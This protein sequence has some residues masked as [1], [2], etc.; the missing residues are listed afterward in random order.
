[1]YITH[2]SIEQKECTLCL[3]KVP[4]YDI[5]QVILTNGLTKEVCEYCVDELYNPQ[6]I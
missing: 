2:D 5:K 4:Y 3:E 1:M 6:D